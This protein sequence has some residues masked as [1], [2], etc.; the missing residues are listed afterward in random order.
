MKSSLHYI[1]GALLFAGLAA[2]LTF[3]S[4]N[5]GFVN[6]DNYMRALHK[7]FPGLDA[8]SRSWVDA[9]AFSKG[10]VQE[11]E[12]LRDR[13]V[14]PWWA[15]TE[16]KLWFFRPL[17]AATHWFD[18]T[19][20]R[21][22][23][24]P[25]HLQNVLW[26]A[27]MCGLAFVLFREFAS[28]PWIAWLAAF[29]FATDEAHG[30]A[31]GWISSRNTLMV[32]CSSIAVLIAHHRWRT[33]KRDVW[34]VAAFAMY[35]I[36]LICGEGA[37]SVCA[38]LFAYAL[39]M[40]FDSWRSRLLSLAPYAAI[41][42]M[43]LAL[44]RVRGFGSAGSA[45]Y[46]D[47]GS[48]FPAWLARIGSNIPILL[49]TEW[50]KWPSEFLRGGDTQRATGFAVVV[51]LLCAA[52]WIMRPM[53]RANARARFWLIGAV[54]AL[55][56]VSAVVAQPRV[57]TISAIGGMA[58]IAEYLSGW[59]NARQFARLI[60]SIVGLTAIVRIADSI[61]RL[62]TIVYYIVGALLIVVLVILV[63]RGDKSAEWIPKAGLR[64]ANATA[65]FCIFVVA[66]LIVAPNTL[67]VQSMVHGA[68]ARKF[69][70]AYASLPFDASVVNRDLILLQGA[71]DFTCYYFMLKRSADVQLMPGHM[72]MLSS[73]LRALTVE[74]PDGSTL[75][76]R[77]D[78][79][80]IADRG[81]SVY[82]SA[83]YPMTQGDTVQLAGL[84]VTVLK[85]DANGWPMDAAFVFDKPLD[86]DL[87]LW[88]TGAMVE[89]RSPRTGRLL[90]VER[91]FPI[92]PPAVGE[93][94]TVRELLE[95][96]PKYQ[97]VLADARDAKAPDS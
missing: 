83:K 61:F 37:I 15:V 28:A 5:N 74:R 73:G 3:P 40:G 25:M 9:F 1:A 67:T 81:L 78:D 43:Y 26:F 76:I 82:R 20:F 45:W 69:D 92:A 58:L 54:I 80:L 97:A 95:R 4:L 19:T 70:A 8:L 84:T 39:V 33:T 59:F 93:T 96:S 10:N 2:A 47:P 34:A 44:Y 30:Y 75:L 94:I 53:L 56:P 64:R 6:D 22:N 52:L 89:E 55:L 14:F 13:G 18:Y 91:Y 57:L 60:G 12:W 23:A 35:G 41:S 24:R 79:G 62:G 66:H 42:A 46:A 32:A 51:L 27:L 48:D 90:T 16:A 11:N 7:G 68:T 71:N 49:F 36:G 85:T 65:L 77:S 86:D 87:Y 31:V 72:R 17:A 21:D 63:R 88:Y 50:F 38:Y 29:M